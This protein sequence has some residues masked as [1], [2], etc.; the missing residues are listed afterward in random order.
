M[1]KRS[2]TD[3]VAAAKARYCRFVDT[4]QWEAFSGLLA[5]APKIR[6]FGPDGDLLFAFDERDAFVALSSQFLEKGRSIH[7]VHNA[8]I[9]ELADGRVS[10]VWSME[11]LILFP[12]AAPG[13]TAR[14][15]GFGH[16]H[17]TYRKGPDGWRIASVRLT[18]LRIS[19]SRRD[20]I[21]L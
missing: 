7:Q 9:E 16:Y 4:K 13:E 11:D 1:T 10:A 21:S 5:E 3:E 14:M 15:N 2:P 19:Q 6:M 8:E 17:E 18:R 12:D 20:R